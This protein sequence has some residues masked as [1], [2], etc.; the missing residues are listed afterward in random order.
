LSI[1]L[2]PSMYFECSAFNYPHNPA[3]APVVVFCRMRQSFEDQSVCVCVCVCV[4]AG[5]LILGRMFHVSF[6][7]SLLQH[8]TER[9]CPF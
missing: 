1:G 6:G 9:L 8:Q 7:I 3:H 5:D 4:T 2:Y